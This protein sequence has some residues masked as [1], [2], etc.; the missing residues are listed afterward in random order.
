VTVLLL[1]IACVYLGKDKYQYMRGQFVVVPL[2]ALWIVLAHRSSSI[3]YNNRTLEYLGLISYSFYLW[4][5]AAIELGKK[6]IV[7]FPLASLHL[8]VLAALTVNVVVSALSYHLVEERARRWILRRFDLLG[9]AGT[10][11][12]ATA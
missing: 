6:I 11:S 2:F 4:Q 9:R 12:T 10:T 8:V 3:F 1:I 5:F 7:W